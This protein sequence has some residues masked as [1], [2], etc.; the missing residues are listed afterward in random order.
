[1]A[2]KT[3][4]RVPAAG[5]RPRSREPLGA[6][7]DD[8]QKVFDEGLPEYHAT[9]YPWSRGVPVLFESEMDAKRHLLAA[10]TGHQL[11]ALL[12]TFVKELA[13]RLSNRFATVTEIYA[14]K[15]ARNDALSCAGGREILWEFFGTRSRVEEDL[16]KLE[17]D[18]EPNRLKVAVVL[19]REVDEALFDKFMRAFQ[20]SRPSRVQY[21]TA[22]DL[23]ASSRF[24][25]TVQRFQHLVDAFDHQD[26]PDQLELVELDLAPGLRRWE[27]VESIPFG[28]AGLR[29][30]RPFQRLQDPVF[31]VDI[32]NKGS[33]EARIAE[34]FINVRFRQTKLHGL[35]EGRL[36]VPACEVELPLDAGD[37]GYRRVRLPTPVLVPPGRHTR[38]RVR[39]KDAGYAWRGEV[40]V[41]FVYGR[42]R[43]LVLPA[44]S[45][46]L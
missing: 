35:A 44:L 37:E 3:R 23:V 2:S 9:Q 30:H 38:L 14:V 17:R 26:W 24:E 22:F 7:A 10:R 12:A 40:E 34:A 45:L 28:F 1:M 15:G 6:A 27:R 19:D 31:V 32:L 4:R 21:I 46:L 18:D 39:L 29:G 11:H 13:S 5:R 43:R 36:L 16:R 41:G 8:L 42:G 33:R 20:G 25:R